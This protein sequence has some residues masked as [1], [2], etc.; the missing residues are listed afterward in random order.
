MVVLSSFDFLEEGLLVLGLYG[1]FV[2]STVADQQIVQ[3]EPLSSDFRNPGDLL[4]V[5]SL[6]LVKSSFTD[7][8]LFTVEQILGMQ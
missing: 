7:D 2:S 4:H 1:G 5:D 6:F 3:A 8:Q